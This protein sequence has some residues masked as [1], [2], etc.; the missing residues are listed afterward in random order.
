MFC[1]EDSDVKKESIKT[2]EAAMHTDTCTAMALSHW[3]PFLSLVHCI[4]ISP[5]P[6]SCGNARACSAQSP[7]RRFSK[8]FRIVH[9]L[10]ILVRSAVDGLLSIDGLSHCAPGSRGF[11]CL[12][13]RWQV[14]A[15]T[16]ERCC[17]SKIPTLCG[18]VE[19]VCLTDFTINQFVLA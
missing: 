15:T 11:D 10:A 14:P 16:P 3:G 18:P 12:S 4:W 6:K 17:G 5:K 19:P 2:L 1:V 13:H 7:V 8:E 9:L